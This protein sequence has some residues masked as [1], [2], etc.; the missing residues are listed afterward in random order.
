MANVDVTKIV[1]GGQN[2]VKVYHKVVE[3]QPS[4]TVTF[5]EDDIITYLQ[6][7]GDFGAEK[8][9]TEVDLF[10]L[11]NKAKLTNGSTITDIE[12]TEAMT[13]DAVTA[14]RKIYDDGSFL[15]SAMF[16]DEGKMIYGCFGQISAWSGSISTSDVATLKYTLVISDDSINCTEPS[17]D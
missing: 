9:T 6:D 11:A 14:M 13:L 12:F 16:N 7:L 5:S 1:R 15:V 3:S 2:R 10:H 4:G 8:D 17:K